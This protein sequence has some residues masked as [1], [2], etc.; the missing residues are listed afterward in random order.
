[1]EGIA[2]E[3]PELSYQIIPIIKEG[4]NSN[5]NNG[6]SKKVAQ[7]LLNKLK[8]D[9]PL[10]FKIDVLRRKICDQV[11]KTADVDTGQVTD[12]H[13]KIAKEQIEISKTL[14]QAKR[15]KEGKSS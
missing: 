2:E 9:D 8:I 4:L 14:M 12:E 3:K 7:E 6:E 15:K 11:G 10:Q 13:R 5:K 1:M